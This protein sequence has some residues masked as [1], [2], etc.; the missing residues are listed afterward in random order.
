[1]TNRREFLT[2]LAAAA[3][4]A[5]VAGAPKFSFAQSVGGKTLIKVFMRGGADGL[6][7][8]PKYNDPAY[9]AYRPDIGIEP[10]SNDINSALDLGMPERGMNPNLELLMEIWDAGNMMVAPA[11]SFAGA[12]RS[13]FDCQRWIG[14][15]ARNN[16]IDGYLNRYMQNVVGIEH[17]LRG[18]VAGK[19]SISTE[20]R[21]AVKVPAIQDNNGFSLQ[22]DDLCEGQGCAD[23]QLTEIM[24]EISSHDV[25]VAA[26]EGAIRETQLIM[27]DAIAEVQ[28]AGVDY[29]PDAGG[30]TYNN[31]DLGRGL[32]MCAQMLKAGVPL[33]VAAVDWNIGWDTHSNQIADG[34]NRFTDQE[35]GYHRN[36]ARGA[37]DFLTFFR[38]MGPAMQDV[39]VLV[40]SEFGRTKKQNGSVGTDHG[41]GGAW[42]AFG[43]PVQR[44]IAP[45]VTTIDDS[46]VERNWL[47]T[48]I[49]YRDIVGE[50]M[51]RHM[52]MSEQLIST[53]FPGHTFTDHRLM[54]AMA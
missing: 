32:R 44:T 17:P 30:L 26:V 25:D 53:V 36:M 21:G 41:E 6:H 33:E 28:A 20:I 45:D 46:V 8:F 49:S 2:S 3:T 29:T 37:N 12:N 52:G 35:K 48:V 51:V 42:F 19:T 31:T 22:N 50:I 18:M 23:N 24:R 47:P 1:M 5:G 11:T 43:G 27:L 13:H 9:Y 54:A 39:V 4:A 10:P 7:L 16:L 14:T 34:T 40:G 38:D 15:G